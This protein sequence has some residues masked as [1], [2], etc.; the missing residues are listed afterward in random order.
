MPE[1]L[2]YYFDNLHC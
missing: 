2:C 1:I